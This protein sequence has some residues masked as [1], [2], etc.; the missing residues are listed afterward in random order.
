MPEIDT[1]QRVIQWLDEIGF[2]VAGANGPQVLPWVEIAAWSEM[3]QTAITP[4]EAA[5]IRRL[6]SE[7][8]SQYFR[9]SDPIAPDPTTNAT[10]DTL[11][12]AANIEAAFG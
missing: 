10:Y 1:H 9:S 11:M 8:V 4:T 5:L 2:Y 7:Y 12:A 6:S 3:T